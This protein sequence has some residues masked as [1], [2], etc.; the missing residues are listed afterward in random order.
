MAR[1]ACSLLSGFSSASLSVCACSLGSLPLGALFFEFELSNF[2]CFCVLPVE[3]SLLPEPRLAL[4]GE[5][6]LF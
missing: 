3:R 2:V 1:C 4:V 5:P 6:R